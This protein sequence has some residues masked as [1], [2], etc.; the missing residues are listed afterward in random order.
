MHLILEAGA[1]VVGVFFFLIGLLVSCGDR[2]VYKPSG[3]FGKADPVGVIIW[4]LMLC[5]IPFALR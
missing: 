5:C 3:F 2:G 1:I 4:I